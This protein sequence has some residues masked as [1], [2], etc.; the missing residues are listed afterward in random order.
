MQNASLDTPHLNTYTYNNIIY[1]FYDN[2]LSF[3]ADITVKSIIPVNEFHKTNDPYYIKNINFQDGDTVIDIGGNLG[4]FSIYLAKQFPGLRIICLEPVPATFENL[5]KNIKINNI[6][7]IIA[8][9]L[10]VTA[11]GRDVEMFLLQELPGSAFVDDYIQYPSIKERFDLSENINKITI[12]STT[13]HHIFE[14]YN[15][16]SCK[17]LKIDCEGS[18]REIL[19]SSTEELQKTDYIIGELHYGKKENNELIKF[20]SAYVPKSHMKFEMK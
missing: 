13:L 20:L 11:D 16:K 1:Q 12:K 15:I 4:I 3:N 2:V 19:E 18:E 8:E 9:N 17:L 14:K 5:K 7:N 10:A 6:T